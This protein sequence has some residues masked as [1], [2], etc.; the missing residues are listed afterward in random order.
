MKDPTIAA[1]E[2]EAEA[3]AVRDTLI[4]AQE[5][6]AAEAAVLPPKQ[7]R[8]INRQKLQDNLWGWAFCAPLIVGTV[9]FIYIALIMALLLSFTTYNEI[10]GDVWAFL[11]RMFS[12]EDVYV[13][14]ADA[15]TLGLTRP[16]GSAMT[17]SYSYKGAVYQTAYGYR[18]DAVTDGY[19]ME[20]FSSTDYNNGYQID[21]GYIPW[22]SLNAEGEGL[23]IGVMW[24]D[25]RAHVYGKGNGEVYLE[26][27]LRPRFRTVIPAGDTYYIP[28][29]FVDAYSGNVDDG[30]NQMKK[31]LFA[32]NMPEVNRLDDS[33]PS[34]EFNLWE[35]LDEERRSWRMSDKKFYEG[36]YQLSELGIDEIT[37]D[38]YWWKDIG[39]WRG[40]HEKWQ[41][42]I[43]YSSEFVNALGMNFSLYMQAGNGSSDHTDAMT[44]IGIS[45]NP[46]WFA[47]GENK[48]WD[49]LCVGDEDARAFLADYLKSYYMELGLDGI[50]TDFGYILG[51]CNKEGHAHIDD[52]DDV[53][54]WTS[55]YV[56]ELFD[57]M[58]ELYPVPTDVNEGSEAH[59]FKWENCNCGGTLKDFASMK[60]ATRIQ[61][62]DAYDPINVRRSFYDAS[63]AFPS[64]QLMLWMNDYMYNPDGPYP[65]DNYRFWSMLM[66]APCPMISMPS[67]MP[68]E[69]YLSLANTVRIYHDWMGEL[70]KYGDLYHILPR[71]DGVNWDGVQYFNPD[72]GKGAVLA[73]KPDPDGT[74]SDTV[75]LNLDGLDDS[76]TYYVWSEE[77]YIP[78]GTYTGA[79]LKAGLDLIIKE[80]YGAEIVYIMDTSVAGAAE[81]VAKPGEFGVQAIA[82]D[83]DFRVLSGG[84]ANAQYYVFDLQRDGT[85]IYG[86][87]SEE[88]GAAENILKGL[89]AGEYTLTVRAYNRFGVTE[90]ETSFTAQG[91]AFADAGAKVS[92]EDGG[93]IVI[94]G[95]RYIKGY[96]LDLGDVKFGASATRTATIT[97]LDGGVLNLRMALDTSDSA[98]ATKVTVYGVKDGVSEQIASAQVK[99]GEKYVDLEVDTAGY[100]SSRR[101]TA[102]R[103]FTAEQNRA[104]THLNSACRYCGT[105]STRL[106][107]RGRLCGVCGRRSFCGDLCRRVL[108]KY[109]H[110]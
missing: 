15:L 95:E 110:L 55:R 60:R 103:D 14:T 74:V 27:G 30:S 3:G 38:T 90:A 11:G 46:N 53:G 52:R 25:C 63:Y 101:V 36:V 86:F 79:Q 81:T 48:I 76:A 107:P 77:G 21:A 32:F 31:W 7:K 9:L 23:N 70:V 12:G 83:G 98:Q 66:G 16:A 50:R 41:S 54:Y 28:E 29:C 91:S 24:S 69:T 6:G 92:G 49:E 17:A 89:P 13:T 75:T 96:S 100:D 97:D 67:D 88:E 42:S 93:E 34:F 2:A 71:A 99:A 108:L 105:G 51:Y 80:S 59:Y 8:R 20:I 102:G 4:G 43:T 58:Y 72:T 57:E 78:F 73:F 1:A 26:A 47:T 56:Y 5:T 22:V 35:L 94:D 109:R 82:E 62:T 45:G 64:M 61:T 39:D 87:I 84:S 37:I 40:V 44:G 65:N 18:C 19:D 85:S 104:I 106:S 33:L 10:Q 68:P